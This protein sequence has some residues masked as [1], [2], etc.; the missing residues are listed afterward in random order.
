MVWHVAYWMP[1][2]R[3]VPPLL[4]TA[5][6]SNAACW[7]H[8]PRACGLAPTTPYRR[9]S[10][11]A[12]ADPAQVSCKDVF[13]LRRLPTGPVARRGRGPTVELRLDGTDTPVCARPHTPAA[14][15]LLAAMSALER[16]CTDA[17]KMLA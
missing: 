17:A 11:I 4:S 16:Q 6:A 12:A 1:V 10:G 9:P 2:L 15:V 14:A 8:C 7:I 3:C 5:I 13:V